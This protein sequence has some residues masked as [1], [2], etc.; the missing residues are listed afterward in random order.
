MPILTLTALN[1]DPTQNTATAI[2]STGLR[3]QMSLI[4]PHMGAAAA[5][6]SM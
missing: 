4:L 2:S 1:S 3:P 5:V 6:A